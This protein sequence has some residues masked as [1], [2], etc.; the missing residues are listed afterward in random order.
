MADEVQTTTPTSDGKDNGSGFSL[1]WKSALIAA[2]VTL[3]LAALV[4]AIVMLV[5]HIRKNKEEVKEGDIK[6]KEC[7]VEEQNKEKNK[8]KENDK[9]KD[10]KSDDKN[11]KTLITS[12]TTVSKPKTITRKF[13]GKDVVGTLG[14]DGNYHIS[15]S[16]II[17]RKGLQDG[18]TSVKNSTNSSINKT[19][20]QQEEFSRKISELGKKLDATKAALAEQQQRKLQVDQIAEAIGA[21]APK[22]IDDL[23]AKLNTFDLTPVL[24]AIPLTTMETINEV[25]TKKE[26]DLPAPPT[27]NEENLTNKENKV[28]KRGQAKLNTEVIN[29]AKEEAQGNSLS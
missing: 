20:Q 7:L 23:F 2:G 8:K 4:F 16:Q 17:T 18:L 19:M 22:V 15:L 9:A 29:K 12:N 5:K 21:A 10:Q 24:N 1:D 25:A 3:G 6:K 27:A 11:V 14:E 26:G 28:V 13:H